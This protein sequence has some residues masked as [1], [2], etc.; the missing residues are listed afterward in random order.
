MERTHLFSPNINVAVQFTIIGAVKVEELKEAIVKAVNCN[1]ILS[2]KIRLRENGDAYYSLSDEPVFTIQIT[3]KDRDEIITNQERIPFELEKGEMVRFFIQPDGNGA[4]LVIIAH[5]LAGDGLSISYLVEDIMTALGGSDPK[6]KPLKL[7]TLKDL[8][9]DSNLNIFMRFLTN[10]LNAGW[11]KSKKVFQFEDYKNMFQRYW[12]DRETVI[13]SEKLDITV[14]DLLQ[15]KSKEHNVTLN[16]LITTVLLR[17]EGK[18]ADT[19]LAVSIREDKNQ[20]MGN[21][22]SGISIIYKYDESKNFW[23]NAACIQKLI[24]KKLKANKNKYFLLQFLGHI[25]STLIDGAYFSAYDGY[26]DKTAELVKNMFGYNNNTKDI[27]ITNLTRL[28]QQLTYGK[29]TITDFIFIPPVVPNAKHMFGIVTLGEN[30]HVV[31][32]V[33]KNNQNSKE[34][35]FFN[36]VM[37]YIREIVNK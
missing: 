19:G 7:C 20:S 15:K 8:P 29:Y 24:Y 11:E 3:E 22:A 23:E 31:M 33:W 30:L 1:Q 27:S 17:A 10:R 26:N 28:E 32:H 25:D 21:F 34:L 4:K 13:F 2:C 36:K 14:L 12:K 5:H 9:K 37:E 6:F 16:S 35:E 18:K